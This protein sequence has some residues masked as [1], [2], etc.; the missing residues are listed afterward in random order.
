[1]V[2]IPTYKSQT[3]PTSEAPGQP[4]RLPDITSAA[5]APALALKDAADTATNLATQF[6]SAQVSLQRKTDVANAMDSI[7]EDYNQL[8]LDQ[9]NNPD[10]A[11]ALQLFKDGSNKLA[12]NARNS[13]SDKVSQRIFDMKF[14]EFDSG[15]TLDVQ[16]SVEQNRIDNAITSYDKEIEQLNY[17]YI[18]GNSNQALKAIQRLSDPESSVFHDMAKLGLLKVKPEVAQEAA[19]Q[20]LYTQ[21]A[22]KLVEDTPQN[23]L[24]KLDKGFWK[25]KLPVETIV[26]FE[27]TAR[28]NIESG[29]KN[30]QTTLKA[31]LRS[32]KGLFLEIG[33]SFLDVESAEYFGSYSQYEELK[34]DGKVLVEQLLAAGLDK[35]AFEVNEFL[36]KME[37][38]KAVHNEVNTYKMSNIDVVDAK[39]AELKTINALT[40]GTD[41]FDSRNEDLEIALQKISDTQHKHIK[42]GTMLEYIKSVGMPIPEIDWMSTDPKSFAQQ[43]KD[44]NFFVNQ[45]S[46]I[47]D[48]PEPQF[49]QEKD[50]ALIKDTFDTGTKEEILT[51]SGNI[52]QVAGSQ[53]P[54]AFSKLTKEFPI[55]TQVGLLMHMNGGKTTPAIDSIVNAHVLLRDET[56]QKIIATLD[57]DSREN[58]ELRQVMESS[59]GNAFDKMPN[60][61]TQIKEAAKY[62]LYDFVLRDSDLRGKL[63]KG[64]KEGGIKKGDVTKL[65]KAYSKSIQM[66]AGMN[67]YGYG[68]IEKFNGDNI[69]ISPMHLNGTLDSFEGLDNNTL[70][71]KDAPSIEELITFMDAELFDQATKKVEYNFAPQHNQYIETLVADNIWLD[72]EQRN[73]S[74]NEVIGDYESIYL[75]SSPL[76]GSYYISFGSPQ[77]FGNEYYLNKNEKKVVLNISRIHHKLLEKWKAANPNE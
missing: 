60:T 7:L 76:L 74:F 55:F 50:L 14:Q 72:G 63:A 64:E 18:Y 32:N 34:Q 53:S 46:A 23:F 9:S 71:G 13:L 40:T 37:G 48:L 19:L 69:I 39:L 31:E 54:S 67:E 5:M 22:E 17:D 11:N 45:V 73:A 49:F 44:Y 68:G 4:T 8:K 61:S 6:Y 52:A 33:N 16:T 26:D 38:Q 47:W 1:M 59:I 29:I 28:S 21:F 42:N 77:D 62:I 36:I 43:V 2:Q 58:T 56:N 30:S 24:F 41:K 65:K 57:I 3:Q 15:H 75:E 70:H 25:D 51:L 12:Q 66:A 35:E 20:N 10:T 27:K